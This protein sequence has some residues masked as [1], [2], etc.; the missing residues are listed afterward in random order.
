MSNNPEKMTT[1][2]NILSTMSGKLIKSLFCQQV[3]HNKF[4][5]FHLEKPSLIS[6][7]KKF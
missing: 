3:L 1:K 2:E 5:V 7:P 4:P 6:K